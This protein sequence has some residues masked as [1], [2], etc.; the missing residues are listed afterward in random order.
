MNRVSVLICS[1]TRFF[2]AARL[3]NGT[4]AVVRDGEPLR[5]RVCASVVVGTKLRATSTKVIIGFKV[6]S[7]FDSF[8]N[9]Y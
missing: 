5:V 1:A 4:V 8:A 9:F 6:N 7:P 2:P 3:S